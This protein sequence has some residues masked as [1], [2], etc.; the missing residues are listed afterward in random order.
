MLRAILF[1]TVCIWP[2]HIR[3]SSILTPKNFIEDSRSTVNPFILSS[4]AATVYYI[5]WWF[6]ERYL[7]SIKLVIRHEFRG[8]TRRFGH[9]SPPHYN[10]KSKAFLRTRFYL[11]YFYLRYNHSLLSYFSFISFFNNYW[12]I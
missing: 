8:G 2:L 10:L 1:S 11:A 12:H 5:F 6:V 7:I 4:K 3:F 9:P